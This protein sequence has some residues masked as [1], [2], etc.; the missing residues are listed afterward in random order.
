MTV[1]LD[2][3]K[4]LR[5]CAGLLNGFCQDI[6]LEDLLPPRR[7]DSKKRQGR[8]DDANSLTGRKPLR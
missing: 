6:T 2:G 4:G 5:Q 3:K 1:L 8:F 7:E